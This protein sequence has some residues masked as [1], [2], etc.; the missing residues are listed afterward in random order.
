MVFFKFSKYDLTSVGNLNRF[1]LKNKIVIP[2]LCTKDD[3]FSVVKLAIDF[4]NGQTISSQRLIFT[5][6]VKTKRSI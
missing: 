6:E 4:A 1:L 5:S 2:F 3:L